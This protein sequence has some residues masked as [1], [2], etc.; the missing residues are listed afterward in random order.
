MQSTEKHTQRKR[1][2]FFW[3]LIVERKYSAVPAL[4]AIEQ[5]LLTSVTV[6]P[7][8]SSYPSKYA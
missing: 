3:S 8:A 1:D 2:I 4:A 6:N 5:M 7:V